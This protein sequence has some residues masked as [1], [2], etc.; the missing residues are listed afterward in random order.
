MRR[1]MKERGKKEWGKGVTVEERE[2][3][4]M[5]DT[6]STPMCRKSPKKMTAALFTHDEKTIIFAD[7]LGDVL[8]FPITFSPD[9]TQATLTEQPQIILGHYSSITSM[10]I[11]SHF[12]SLSQTLASFIFVNRH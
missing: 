11:Y 3:G 1:E 4:E 2:G 5:K 9:Y 10:V 8:H 7:K 6:N 12:S